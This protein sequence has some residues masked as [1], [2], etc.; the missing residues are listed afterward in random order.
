MPLQEEALE[1]LV[2]RERAGEGKKLFHIPE[3]WIP[4]MLRKDLQLVVIRWAGP[5]QAGRELGLPV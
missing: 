2:E 4:S 1:L 3:S 5:P